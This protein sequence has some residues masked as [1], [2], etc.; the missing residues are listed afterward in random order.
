MPLTVCG[1][2]VTALRVIVFR[3]TSAIVK[4]VISVVGAYLVAIAVRKALYAGNIL[5]DAKAA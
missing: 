1:F 5:Q 2:S 4:D 3:Q